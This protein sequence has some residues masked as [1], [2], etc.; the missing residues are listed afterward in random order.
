[1]PPGKERK[2][3]F[4]CELC[5]SSF[6]SKHH[7]RK[8]VSTVHEDILSHLF[9]RIKQIQEESSI[10][11]CLRCN[12]TFRSKED[13]I[14]HNK[15]AHKADKAHKE[16]QLY[17]CEICHEEFTDK[18]HLKGHIFAVHEEKKPLQCEICNSFFVGQTTYERHISAVHDGKRQFRCET[19]HTSF[20]LEH[21]LK[22]S[23][24]SLDEYRMYVSKRGHIDRTYSV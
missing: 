17:K 19:C 22:H 12:R 4:E 14:F 10:L 1:M 3:P 11:S 5:E 2:K 21:Y 23:C 13:L 7:L 24:L 20:S 15:V 16:K 8:H 6:V 9:D 18:Y